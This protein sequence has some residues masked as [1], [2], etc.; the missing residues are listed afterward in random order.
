M[1]RCFLASALLL[2]SVSSGCATSHTLLATESGTDRPIT[3]GEAACASGCSEICEPL[4]LSEASACGPPS[5]CGIKSLCG[6]CGGNAGCC[7]YAGEGGRGCRSR[8]FSGLPGGFERG[9]KNIALDGVGWVLGIPSKLLLWNTRVD[10]HSVSPQT[11]QQLRRYLTSRGLDDVKVRVNQYAPVDEWKRLVKNKGIHPG[12]R[13]TVGTLVLTR[14][15]LL[16]GRLF[17]N[18]EYNAFT[19]SISLYSD[20]QSIALREGAHAKQ[21]MEATYPGLWSASSYLPG[22]P[23]WIDTP[24]VREVLSWSRQTQQRKLERESYLVLFPA[25]GARLGSSATFFLDASLGQAAQGGF[26]LIGHAVGRTKAFGVSEGSIEMAKSV[27]G[28]VKKRPAED[29]VWSTAPDQTAEL[30]NPLPDDVDIDVSFVPL[31][32]TYDSFDEEY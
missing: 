13:Y 30:Q 29:D 24:A 28:I 22:S 11:E 7:G 23:L 3:C 8:A 15:T 21:A 25:F 18:D 12:W 20:R 2:L 31:D 32:V 14:Y 6:E 26:A 5:C 4:L 16:P 27:Y 1:D 9:K 19:N 10:S 17:G